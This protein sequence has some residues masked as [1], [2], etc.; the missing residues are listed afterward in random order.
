VTGASLMRPGIRALRRPHKEKSP[1][2]CGYGLNPSLGEWR[3]QLHYSFRYAKRLLSN[4]DIRYPFGQYQAE[5]SRS[6]P[7]AFALK[8]IPKSIYQHIWQ[9]QRSTDR[10]PK[11]AKHIYPM[12]LSPPAIQMIVDRT[13]ARATVRDLPSV[14]IMKKANV[15]IRCG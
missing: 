4:R 11:S 7:Q 1:Q 6:S 12:R 15:E 14:S 2:P 13:K 9:R 8:F 10:A 3:R 5:Y